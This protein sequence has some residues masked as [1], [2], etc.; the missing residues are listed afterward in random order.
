MDKLDF[1]DKLAQNQLGGILLDYDPVRRVNGLSQAQASHLH[2]K[3]GLPLQVPDYYGGEIYVLPSALLPEISGYAESAWQ[4]T[5][6]QS[7]G[8]NPCFYTEEH[9]MNFVLAH[10]SVV[11][12]KRSIRRVWTT[13][14]HRTVTGDESNLS[15]WHL[16]AEKGRGFRKTF[17]FALDTESWFWQTE[18]QDFVRRSASIMGI[19]HRCLSRWI[20]DQLGNLANVFLGAK[21]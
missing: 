10:F 18:R 13:H 1:I 8:K 2:S 21:Q 9:I 7:D 16:P 4:Y 12:L 15:L 6:E 17:P 20:P 3:L 5:L 11:D 14:R 19:D